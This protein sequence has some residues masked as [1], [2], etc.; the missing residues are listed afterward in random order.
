VVARS[1]TDLE[2][3]AEFISRDSAFYAAALVEELLAVASSLDRFSERGRIV[4]EVGDSTVREL[5]VKGYRLLYKT[6]EGFVLVLGVI[7][8]RRDL[9]RVG[10]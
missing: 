6:G 4:P 10:E 8:G 1:G 3:I 2:A 5:F 7:H 9:G